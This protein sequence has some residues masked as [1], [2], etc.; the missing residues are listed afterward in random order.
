[1]NAKFLAGSMQGTIAKVF[2]V[3]S[4]FMIQI[5]GMAF[6]QFGGEASARVITIVPL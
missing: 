3:F 4:I 6:V 5:R 2:F 1:M